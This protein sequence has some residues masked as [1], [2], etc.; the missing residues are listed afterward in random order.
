MKP[1]KPSEQAGRTAAVLAALGFLGI[2]LFQ[3]ALAAGADWGHAAWGGADAE[4]SSAQ[5]IGSAAAAL[6][7]AAAAVLVLGR[8]GFL[9]SDRSRTGSSRWGTWA[10]AALSGM[11][12][13]ANFASEPLRKLHL[14]SSGFASRDPVR[15]RRTQPGRPPPPRGPTALIRR[16][17]NWNDRVSPMRAGPSGGSWR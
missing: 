12:A 8:A 15:R 5:R 4:L 1:I 7:W 9:G 3:V 14:G 10:A 13:L 16:N 17:R 6:I 2:A 11:G